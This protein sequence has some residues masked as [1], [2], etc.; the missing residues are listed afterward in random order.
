MRDPAAEKMI[1]DYWAA[2]AAAQKFDQEAATQRLMELQRQERERVDAENAKI[3]AENRAQQESQARRDA[4]AQVIAQRNQLAAA[5]AKQPKP[6]FVPPTQAQSDAS[7]ARVLANKA[8]AQKQQDAVE[9]QERARMAAAIGEHPTLSGSTA[10][11]TAQQAINKATGGQYEQAL[12]FNQATGRMNVLPL[13]QVKANL[14]PQS[15]AYLEKSLPGGVQEWYNKTVAP[16]L[17]GSIQRWEASPEGQKFTTGYNQYQQKVSDY[18]ARRNQYTRD[19]EALMRAARAAQA[20]RQKANIVPAP[21]GATKLAKGGSVKASRG[22]GC[23][24]R[25]KTKGRMV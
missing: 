4:A 21:Q 9:A 5:A 15:A 24:Q 2:Q 25:G 16:N 8:A 14:N 13:E 20:A 18:D 19:Q 6:K 10:F 22:D 12:G 17:Q 23:A 11:Q 3:A 1:N 7:Y